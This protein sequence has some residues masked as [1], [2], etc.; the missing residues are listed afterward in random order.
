MDINAAWAGFHPALRYAI[1]FGAG[2]LLGA[3]FF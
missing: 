3:I 2:F 1:M